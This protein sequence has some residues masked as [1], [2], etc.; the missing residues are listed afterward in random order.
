MKV[1]V[2]AGTF[3]IVSVENPPLPIS[4]TAACVSVWQEHRLSPGLIFRFFH[5]NM[6]GQN[7]HCTNPLKI[8]R[9]GFVQSAVAQY[10]H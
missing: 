6:K 3:D 2:N 7:Q 9:E 10:L 1:D 8:L 4:A 5:L